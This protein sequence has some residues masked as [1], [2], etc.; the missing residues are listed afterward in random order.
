MNMLTQQ[1]RE[2]LNLK[3]CQIGDLQRQC[4]LQAMIIDDLMRGYT[5]HHQRDVLL[6]R[7]DMLELLMKSTLGINNDYAQTQQTCERL[8]SSLIWNP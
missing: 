6:V 8:R 1:A 2:R 5:D 7:G 4:D 3:D